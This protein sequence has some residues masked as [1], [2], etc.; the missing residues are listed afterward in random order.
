M[1]DIVLVWFFALQNVNKLI[2]LNVQAWNYLQYSNCTLGLKSDKCLFLSFF[3]AQQCFIKILALIDIP[4]LKIDTLQYVNW[5]HAMTITMCLPKFQSHIQS[6]V[7]E[8]AFVFWPLP[9]INIRLIQQHVHDRYTWT[10]KQFFTFESTKQR[11][12]SR[13][14]YANGTPC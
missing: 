11:S 3:S 10:E 6:H 1:L 7:I 2:M 4:I 12:I 5:H 8:L 9:Q 13:E 14:Q